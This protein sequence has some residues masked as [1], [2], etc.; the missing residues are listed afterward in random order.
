[1]LYRHKLRLVTPLGCH[2]ATSVASVFMLQCEDSAA[3]SVSCSDSPFQALTIGTP[4]PAQLVVV[5]KPP[6]PSL[7]PCI[8]LRSPP[9]P[10]RPPQVLPRLRD[11]CPIPCELPDRS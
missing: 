10:R 6:P 9:Y 4:R 7:R 1:M 11:R 5:V 3:V 8:A 2:L